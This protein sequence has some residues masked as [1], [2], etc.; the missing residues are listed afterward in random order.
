MKTVLNYILAL[1]ILSSCSSSDSSTDVQI[2]NDTVIVYKHD[3]VKFC[4]PYASLSL[5]ENGC[6]TKGDLTN[7]D[8]M[9]LKNNELGYRIIS[10]E[11]SKKQMGKVIRIENDGAKFNKKIV[12]LF[13]KTIDSDILSFEK[14]KVVNANN[15][16]AILNPVI[17]KV[18][19]IFEN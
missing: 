17:I 18:V 14:I 2:R 15:D 8:E 16:T 5:I 3:T 11:C 1:F 7:T 9:M 4:L 6:V 10:F 19:A 13:N 12:D